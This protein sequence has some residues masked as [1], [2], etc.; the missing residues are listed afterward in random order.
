MKGPN[1]TFLFDINKNE[2]YYQNVVT[3]ST[4]KVELWTLFPS[5]NIEFKIIEVKQ[6]SLSFY[7]HSWS[8][9]RQYLW[10]CARSYFA[11]TSLH[12]IHLMLDVYLDTWFVVWLSLVWNE[13]SV[14]ASL[15]CFCKGFCVLCINIMS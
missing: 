2:M 11:L 3:N 4:L 14:T 9:N 7:I 15:S 10:H 6:N 13:L 12:G 8:Y 5:R 1:W